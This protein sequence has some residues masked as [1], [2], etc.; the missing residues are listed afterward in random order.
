MSRHRRMTESQA[1]R[2]LYY[3]RILRVRPI[4]VEEPAERLSFVFLPRR[5]DKKAR[6][7]QAY[8]P[9]PI[10]GA[11]REVRSP[12]FTTSGVD[13]IGPVPRLVRIRIVLDC[14]Y[15]P[16]RCISPCESLELSVKRVD[17]NVCVKDAPSLFLQKRFVLQGRQ[18]GHIAAA[19]VARSSTCVSSSTLP[20]GVKVV[21][22][23]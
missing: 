14:H 5:K 1:S 3:A 10:Y 7:L 15:E 12:A 16:S 11:R 22:R 13:F 23:S 8:A 9:Q 19:P 18:L 17:I 21:C 6:W 2:L 4:A 20:S